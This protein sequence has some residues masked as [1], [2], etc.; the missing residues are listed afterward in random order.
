MDQEKL[1]KLCRTHI[2]SLAGKWDE[3]FHPAHEHKLHPSKDVPGNVVYMVEGKVKSVRT[4]LARYLGRRHKITVGHDIEKG[5][6]KVQ[7]GLMP[8]TDFGTEFRVVS[9]PDI[10]KIYE[11][12]TSVGSCMSGHGKHTEFYGM[13]PD[14]IQLLVWN[15]EARDLGR[16]LLWRTDEGVLVRDYT[17]IGDRVGRE[18]YDLWTKENGAESHLEYPRQL[19]TVTFGTEIVGIPMPK[20][21]TFMYM[22]EKGQ[23][24][25]MKQPDSKWRCDSYDGKPST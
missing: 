8:P 10:C 25:N 4:T 15:K 2:P 6:A 5:I 20:I 3:V 1:S 19:R 18:R 12:M 11:D 17:Y 21:D 13:F 24:T 9:G 16:S 23:L 14:K 7:A 22:N